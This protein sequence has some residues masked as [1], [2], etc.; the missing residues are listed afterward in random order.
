M[1]LFRQPE[2][3]PLP[4]KAPLE[5]PDQDAGQF[6]AKLLGKMTIFR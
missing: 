6:S 4:F 2:A 5:G 3:V 1:N